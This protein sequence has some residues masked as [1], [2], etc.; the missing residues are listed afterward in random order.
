MSGE[1]YR[2]CHFQTAR[3]FPKPVGLCAD[4]SKSWRVRKEVDMPCME[5][6]SNGFPFH[7]NTLEG[8]GP[9]VS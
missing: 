2:D 9:K 1:T 3:I 8:Q 7:E 4:V 5:I 6:V